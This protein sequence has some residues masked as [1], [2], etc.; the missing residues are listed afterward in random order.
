MFKLHVNEKAGWLD[1]FR[2]YA[3]SQKRKNLKLEGGPRGF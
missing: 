3:Y 1:D 2:D